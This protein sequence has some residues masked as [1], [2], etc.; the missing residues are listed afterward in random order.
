M[1]LFLIYRSQAKVENVQL[2]VNPGNSNCQGK[3]KLLPIIGASSCRGFEQKEQIHLIKVV[4]CLYMFY[5]KI[6][7]NARA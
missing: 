3:L 1:L 7:I 2:Q 4:L 5:C 6:S